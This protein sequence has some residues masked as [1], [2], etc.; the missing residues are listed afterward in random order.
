MGGGK[1]NMPEME[2][3]FRTLH[4]YYTYYWQY[5]SSITGDQSSVCSLIVQ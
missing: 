2:N 3:L 4:T 5:I 1:K